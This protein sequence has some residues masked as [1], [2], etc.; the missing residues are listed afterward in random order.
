M[1]T[2]TKYDVP[3]ELFSDLPR[4][5]K[6]KDLIDLGIRSRSQINRDIASG[7]LPAYKV[8]GRI[9]ILKAD[10]LALV[11]PVRS[12]MSAPVVAR[13]DRAI[14]DPGALGGDAA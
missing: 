7:R 11:R 6:P 9:F 5:L 14:S 12:G 3:D 4:R 2:K 10:V 8:G 13:T 1:A